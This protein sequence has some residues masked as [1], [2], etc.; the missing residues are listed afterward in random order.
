MGRE[1]GQHLCFS[2]GSNPATGHT[3]LSFVSWNVTFLM[4]FRPS[5]IV[6]RCLSQLFKNNT[7]MMSGQRVATHHD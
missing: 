6:P 1:C 3:P 2:L 4:S 7:P 5:P